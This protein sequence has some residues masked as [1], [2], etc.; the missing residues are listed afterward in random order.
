MLVHGQL[1]HLNLVLTPSEFL[2]ASNAPSF[3]A[4]SE[5][6]LPRLSPTRN[7]AN[8]LLHPPKLQ[9]NGKS[10]VFASSPARC[11]G[12]V[13]WNKGSEWQGAGREGGA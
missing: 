9:S 4:I 10:L 2:L 3:G 6:P 5:D 1:P 11:S 7:L 12:R 8:P 13:A